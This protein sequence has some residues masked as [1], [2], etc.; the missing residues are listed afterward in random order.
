MGGDV[1]VV[2][3]MGNGGTGGTVVPFV[4]FVAGEVV[5]AV[6]ALGAVWASDHS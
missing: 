4:P 3:L 5:G 2:V 6:T 1:E